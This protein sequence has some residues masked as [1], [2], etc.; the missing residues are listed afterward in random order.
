[1]PRTKPATSLR[2]LTPT[3]SPRESVAAAIVGVPV[4]KMLH[5]QP[6]VFGTVVVVD[7]VLVVLVV[8]VLVLVLVTVVVV[9][10]VVLGL[11]C[12]VVEPLPAARRPRI[13]APGCAPH[14]PQN[15]TTGV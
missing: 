6:K 7:V 1:M 15:D 14:P 12:V 5:G 10:F 2:N 8:L 4:G 13:T 11:D 9:A 3:S